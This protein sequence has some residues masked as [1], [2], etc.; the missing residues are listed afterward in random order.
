MYTTQIV[1]IFVC[2]VDLM[3]DVFC[4]PI[5]KS[6]GGLSVTLSYLR[7]LMLVCVLNLSLLE[8]SLNGNN[9]NF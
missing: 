1:V 5:Y 6:K 7:L 3:D 4:F 8:S 9:V 2:S